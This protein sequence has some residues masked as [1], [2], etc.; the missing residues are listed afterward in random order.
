MDRVPL[1]E[2]AAHAEEHVAM[3]EKNVAEFRAVI[4]G[5][6]TEA[7]DASRAKHMLETFESSLAVQVV[8]RNR[9]RAE[10]KRMT[11]A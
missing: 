11:D 1:L 8:D 5:M 10:L 3:A 4:D 9:L 7:F 6:A 2:Y